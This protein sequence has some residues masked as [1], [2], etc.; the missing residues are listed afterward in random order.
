MNTEKDI[1]V[2]VENAKNHAERFSAG[3]PS[4]LKERKEKAQAL[5]QASN[6][7]APHETTEEATETKKVTIRTVLY[8]LMNSYSFINIEQKLYVY[9]EDEGY[10]KMLL[11]N[12]NNREL[13]A[14]IPD[15]YMEKVNKNFLYELHEWLIIHSTK[16]SLEALREG[17]HCLNFRDV[18][19]DWKDGKVL[20]SRKN[21]YFTYSLKLN[22]KQPKKSSGDFLKFIDDTFQHD[23][24]L[25]RE[26][27]KFFAL[28]LSPIRHL[29]LAFFLLGPSDTSK[30]IILEFL[31][32]LAGEENCTSL[33]FSKMNNDFA[34]A[35]LLGARL[36]LSGESSGT[37][38]VRLES[39]KALVGN[40]NNSACFKNKDFFEFHN[41]A[42]LVYAVNSLPGIKEVGEAE[43]Y[44]SRL[45]IFPMTRV[46]KREDWSFNL[47]NKIIRED[48]AGIVD[49]IIEGMQMLKED[50]YIFN[51]TESME[52]CKH[53]YYGEYDSFSL[54]ARKYIE[55]D[56]TSR[57]SSAEITE[58]YSA[59]CDKHLYVEL[60]SNQWPVNLE[61]IFFCKRCFVKKVVKGKDS[62]V[63]GYSGIKFKDEVKDLFE[64][65]EDPESKDLLVKDVQ[66][67]FEP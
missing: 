60:K 35:Q 52:E 5:S 65:G 17:R 43:S 32:V 23:K 34:I 64:K 31:R 44:L 66:D 26:F 33:S 30:S 39:F 46:V 11:P 57:L 40:D 67:L 41:M 10:W 63:R 28:A 13:R 36:N 18:A 4:F 27:Q 15:E 3:V 38:S 21:M 9:I 22:Y 48:S 2:I 49:F 56:H 59:F 45:V 25:I 29:K 24:K 12:D 53:N 61:K 16:T 7:S 62:Q 58:A 50:D 42:L 54:F 6:I 1:T 19:Y 55:A 20:D 37:S 51:P 14:L 47:V 8:E